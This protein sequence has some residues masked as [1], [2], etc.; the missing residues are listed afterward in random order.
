VWITHTVNGTSCL[1]S[2]GGAILG[3]GVIGDDLVVVEQGGVWRRMMLDGTVRTQ[4]AHPFVR[5]VVILHDGRHLLLVGST[6][7]DRR[8]EFHNYD[9]R[10][11]RIGIPDQ[12]VP[13]V[14]IDALRLAWVSNAGMEVLKLAP[15]L[16]FR[17]TEAAGTRL[18]LSGGRLLGLGSDF[19][20]IWTPEMALICKAKIRNP[21][22]ICAT[23]DGDTVAIGTATGG[24]ALV[25]LLRDPREV[26]PQTMHAA[27]DP[28]RALSFE[29]SGKW[30]ASG[31][32]RL[33]VWSVEG[34]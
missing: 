34:Y 32:A 26:A 25:D 16:S 30:L 9:R 12:A 14:E 27:D 2:G 18:S 8:I 11:K 23:H 31:A 33:C 5:D 13:I 6:E 1:L 15:G 20:G 29:P 17:G 4:G 22:A 3:L 7:T 21:T 28:I 19:A 24:V 10:V